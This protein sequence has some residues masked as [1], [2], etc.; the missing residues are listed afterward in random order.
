MLVVDSK[1]A[2]VQ[3]LR[4]GSNH[5]GGVIIPEDVVLAFHPMVA[6]QSWTNDFFLEL[7]RDL[8]IP[9]LVQILS[10]IHI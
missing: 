10:L 4:R 7:F 9:T 8:D 1:L 6:P 2:R 5:R 3:S